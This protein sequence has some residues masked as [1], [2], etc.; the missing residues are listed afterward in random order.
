MGENCP[1]CGNEVYA[2]YTYCSSCGWEA[3][4]K[5]KA[6]AET[7]L[8]QERERKMAARDSRIKKARA[9]TS[10][11]E[12]E[13]DREAEDEEAGDGSW[14]ED[15]ADERKRYRE[16]YP[17]GVDYRHDR[18]AHYH[19]Y[20]RGDYRQAGKETEY[21]PEKGAVRTT[22]TRIP[23]RCGAEIIV[24]T[25]RRPVRI[26]CEECGAK[27]VL[28]GPKREPPRDKAPP[29]PQRDVRRGGG[30]RPPEGR[31]RQPGRPKPQ[32]GRCAVCGSLRLRFNDDGSGMCPDCNRRFFWDRE[33]EKRV[34]G[35]P[36]R[37]GGGRAAAEDREEYYC[38]NCDNPLTYIRMYERWYCDYC[39]KYV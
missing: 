31:E 4:G 37:P 17:S 35:G 39:R 29:K 5:E 22:P 6:R 7:K 19:R 15:E 13:D 16:D 23:C 9:E 11:E 18:G 1:E 2:P 21:A 10:R 30:G 32:K 24:R 28:K 34:P 3:S 36:P 27:A 8:R 25:S 12:K 33:A 14:D 26:Q 20:D 38:R